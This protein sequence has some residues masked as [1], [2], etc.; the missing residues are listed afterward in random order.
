MVPQGVIDFLE[1][2]QVEEHD[3][4]LVPGAPCKGK[5]LPEAIIH[6]RAIWEIG[7]DI[8]MRHGE[9][10]LLILFHRRDVEGN[11]CIICETPPLIPQRTHRKPCGVAVAGLTVHPYLTLPVVLFMDLR[12]SLLRSKLS[13]AFRYTM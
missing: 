8:I 12:G 9:K 10:A 7:E 11:P 4:N 2:I 13:R 3:P 6:E 1:A 5:C